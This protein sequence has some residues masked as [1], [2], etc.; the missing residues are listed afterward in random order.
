MVLVA[1]S[2]LIVAETRISAQNESLSVQNGLASTRWRLTSFGGESGESSL[3]SGTQISLKF[4]TDGRATGFGGCN[5]YA[6]SYEVTGGNI[7]FNRILSTK[8]AR[9]E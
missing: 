7:T 5:S 1:N 2:D 6:A 4:G 8:K 3:V 9:L